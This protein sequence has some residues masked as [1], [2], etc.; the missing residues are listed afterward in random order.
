MVVSAVVRQ[1]E[2]G[3]ARRVARKALWASR[4]SPSPP[5]RMLGFLIPTRMLAG[6]Y[7][8]MQS[9]GR[10]E[11]W[12]AETPT[13]MAAVVGLRRGETTIE[14]VDFFSTGELLGLTLAAELLQRLDD[15]ELSVILDT[16]GIRHENYFRRLGFEPAGQGR[17]IR[18][19]AREGSRLHD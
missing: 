9:S 8:W 15:Q 14:A 17:M 2:P 3:D 11:V 5:A 10:G 6:I 18:H 1:M 12:V 4:R 13:A 19:P 16:R 7:R